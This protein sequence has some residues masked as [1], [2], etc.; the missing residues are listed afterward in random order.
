[1]SQYHQAFP[2]NLAYSIH[3]HCG[4]ACYEWVLNGSHRTVGELN[5]ACELNI[6][7]AKQGPL[8]PTF[9]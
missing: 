3:T 4:L 9:I 1:M 7:K 2:P 6:P 8:P 5:P